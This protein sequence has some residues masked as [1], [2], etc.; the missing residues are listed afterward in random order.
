MKRRVDKEVSAINQD[1][2]GIGC[3]PRYDRINSS[4]VPFGGINAVLR[5]TSQ[6]GYMAGGFETDVGMKMVSS[7]TMWFQQPGK[8]TEAF[9]GVLQLRARCA[10]AIKC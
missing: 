5:H 3:K 4:H 6:K 8:L 7:A 1:K 10:I 9:A 2:R